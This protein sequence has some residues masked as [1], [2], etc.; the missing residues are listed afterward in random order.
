[1]FQQFLRIVQSGSVQ[2]QFEIAEKMAVSPAMVLQIARELTTRGYLTGSIDECHTPDQ[3][4]TGCPIGSSCH[5]Q[6]NAWVLSEKGQK[7]VRESK[8]PIIDN[9]SI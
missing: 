7:V 9:L 1:M 6:M 5:T 3:V 2:N 8:T 4:C